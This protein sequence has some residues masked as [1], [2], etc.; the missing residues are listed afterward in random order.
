MSSVDNVLHLLFEDEDEE[1]SA[2]VQSS[3][4]WYQES[5]LALLPQPKVH[6]NMIH[7]D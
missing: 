7:C 6:G 1:A 2:M 5:S 4:F 3:L